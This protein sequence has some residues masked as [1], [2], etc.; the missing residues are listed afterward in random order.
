MTSAI[1]SLDARPLLEAYGP[2]LDI[3][4]STMNELV[5]QVRNHCVERADFFTQLLKR[6]SELIE[7]FRHF[8]SLSIAHLAHS[9]ASADGD[10]DAANNSLDATSASVAAAAAAAEEAI[11]GV[12]PNSKGKGAGAPPTGPE[13][14][15]SPTRKAQALAAS[16]V[17]STPQSQQSMTRHN[18]LPALAVRPTSPAVAVRGSAPN[19]VLAEHAKQ[20]ASAL[21]SIDTADGFAA[22]LKQ[23]ES[24]Q[25]LISS[26]APAPTPAP[27]P[28]GSG[29]GSGLSEE[30]TADSAARPM[31]LV[32][33]AN[34]ATGSAE[35]PLSAAS[36][37]GGAVR[38][39]GIKQIPPS[40]QAGGA[41][42]SITSPTA[43]GGG[44][45]PPPPTIVITEPSA[46]PD[47][48]GGDGGDNEDAGSETDAKAG[49][50]LEAMLLK[51][52]HA[53]I[54]KTAQKRHASQNSFANGVWALC[55]LQRIHVRPTRRTPTPTPYH[56]VRPRLTA[57]YNA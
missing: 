4:S 46:S 34:A 32:L 43:G 2:E 1:Q 9:A 29:N 35:I 50:A 41:A 7:H 16:I 40:P 13:L 19:P 10:D 48:A 25:A 3:L 24:V 6:Q 45:A 27:A 33:P 37:N 28:N 57:L 5:G 30:K 49:S 56:T 31:Q 42:P 51:Q 8:L 20:M 23:V 14:P 44:A 47:K 21:G 18:S 15:M 53:L 52:K 22:F 12:R 38:W 54:A 17:A 11:G 36:D 55:K 39:G 26:P